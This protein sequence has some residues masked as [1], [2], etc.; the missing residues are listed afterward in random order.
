[1]SKDEVMKVIGRAKE[2]KV[3][4]LGFLESNSIEDVCRDYN[5]IGPQFLPERLRDKVTSLLAIY[6]P[7]ALVHDLRFG[8]SDGTREAFDYANC[9]FYVNCHKCAK[10]AYP[11]W[12]WRRYRAYAVIDA[13]H[14]FNCA[15]FGGWRAWLDA[16]EARAKDGISTGGAVPS[17][18]KE[19]ER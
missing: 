14:E 10:A 11:W 7:A 15:D 5:G 1:M 2:L 19:N 8:K 4:G 12:S 6:E 9:E 3:M 17:G 16:H 18:N 13:M